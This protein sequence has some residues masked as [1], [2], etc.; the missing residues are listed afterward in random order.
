MKTNTGD[1][2]FPTA[3]AFRYSGDPQ[4][5]RVA[6]E[7]VKIV[8]SVL[9]DLFLTEP[10]QTDF[11]VA[12][13]EER[14]VKL[15]Q[16]GESET[17]RLGLYLCNEFGWLAG[18]GGDINKYQITNRRIND[19]VVTLK[20]FD[21][22]WDGQI[23]LRTPAGLRERQPSKKPVPASTKKTRSDWEEIR[24]LGTGGQE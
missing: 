21:N 16:N 5:E 17:I 8:A 7:S 24:K 10:N 1:D 19:R 11:T 2:F 3:L 18:W 9:Q 12:N 22:L 6:K 4:Y 23:E 20:D 13:V 14:A 15:H